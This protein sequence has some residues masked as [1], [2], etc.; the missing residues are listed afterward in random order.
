MFANRL[1]APCGICGQQLGQKVYLANTVLPFSRHTL[2]DDGAPVCSENKKLVVV[3]GSASANSV[4]LL[5][6]SLHHRSQSLSDFSRV[7]QSV[8]KEEEELGVCFCVSMRVGVH[9]CN[10]LCT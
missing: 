8:S 1:R 6:F 7:S 9:V 3:R 2:P 10:W 4:V 5:A